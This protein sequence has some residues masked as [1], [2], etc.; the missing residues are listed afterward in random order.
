MRT[1]SP[2]AGYECRGLLK[3]DRLGQDLRHLVNIVHAAAL[4]EIPEA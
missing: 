3:L 1:L 4:P 2:Q